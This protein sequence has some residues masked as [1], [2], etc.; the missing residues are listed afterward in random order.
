MK[1]YLSLIII[2]TFPIIALASGSLNPNLEINFIL[3]VIL[4]FI[5]LFKVI[6][7]IKKVFKTKKISS[8]ST[9]TLI[10]FILVI[11]F[12]VLTLLNSCSGYYFSIFASTIPYFLFFSILYFVLSLVRKLIFLNKFKLSV[13]VIISLYILVH[14]F[15]LFF[16]GYSSN[17]GSLLDL[18]LIPPVI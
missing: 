8:T 11:A 10:S 12:T 4:S 1:K 14:L 18:N 2:S 16:G 9:L 15:L 13:C 5:L 7:E 3:S 6:L 17:C